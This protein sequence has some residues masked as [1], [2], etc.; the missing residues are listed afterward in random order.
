MLGKTLLWLQE[1]VKIWKKPAT[2]RRKRIS[3]KCISFLVIGV[4]H[5]MKQA[6]LDRKWQSADKISALNSK[7]TGRMSQVASTGADWRAD[8]VIMAR[9]SD[10]APQFRGAEAPSGVAGV[11][12]VVWFRPSHTH[13]HF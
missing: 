11:R 7:K 4:F 10:N 5:K 13:K 2:P 6:I 8:T 12:P 9:N 3:V 1:R